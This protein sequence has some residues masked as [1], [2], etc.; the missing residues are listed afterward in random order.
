M[1][2]RTNK[3]TIRGKYPEEPII[4]S[5]F[6]GD[7]DAIHTINV[8]FNKG[9]Q[10]LIGTNEDGEYVIASRDPVTGAITYVSMQKDG[11]IRTN[12]YYLDGTMEE[13]ITERK[14]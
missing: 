12:I 13:S 2:K 6:S 4:T 11:R 8:R 9:L 5:Q 10:P 1:A 3:K 7:V 14:G